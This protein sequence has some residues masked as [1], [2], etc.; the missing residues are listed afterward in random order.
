VTKVKLTG[1]LVLL[2]IVAA[3]GFQITQSTEDSE[4]VT[5]V[6]SVVQKQLRQEKGV[7]LLITYK[8]SDTE[9]RG[10]VKHKGLNPWN[11]PVSVRKGATVFLNANQIVANELTCVISVP[12][13]NLWSKPSTRRSIGSVACALHIPI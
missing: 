1:T 4:R 13:M 12:S 3:F 11:K 2:I 5:A 9:W 7:S 8:S 6:L 10:P